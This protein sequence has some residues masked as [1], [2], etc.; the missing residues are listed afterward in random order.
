[1]KIKK[2]R[3]SLVPESDRLIRVFLLACMAINYVLC[4][5]N[6]YIVGFQTS[7][8]CE[9]HIMQHIMLTA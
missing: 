8:F 4:V 7:M 6:A 9:Q 2:I 1:M 3:Y 5:Y